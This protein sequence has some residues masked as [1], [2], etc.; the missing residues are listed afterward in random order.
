MLNRQIPY[1]ICFLLPAFSASADTV[2][3]TIGAA[4]WNQEPSGDVAYSE[5]GLATEIDFDDTLDLSG[6]SEGMYWLSIEHP[7]PMFPN[8]KLQST[9]ISSDGTETAKQDITFGNTVYTAGTVLDSEVELNQTDVVLYYEV[10]DNAFSLDLGLDVKIMDA[11]FSVASST[12][13]DE[14]TVSLFVPMLYGA[15][16]FDLPFTGAYLGGSGSILAISGNSYSD[17]QLNLGYESGIGLG[18]E[19]GYR[20]QK[21]KLDDVEDITAD[22]QFS[23]A[24]LGVFYHF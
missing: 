4:L 19:G 22:F 10:L 2:G 23:G 7:V 16:R 1:L 24:Y 18:V 17:Y 12:D 8:L 11:K 15:A 9:Q 21:V 3:F 5:S 6:E 14:V 13:E 20:V